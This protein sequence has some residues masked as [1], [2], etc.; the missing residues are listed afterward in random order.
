MNY[1]LISERKKWLNESNLEYFSKMEY[2]IKTKQINKNR[3][4][5]LLLELLEHIIIA[6]KEERLAEEE[7]GVDP[8]AYSK[9][10][11]ENIPSE[12]RKFSIKSKVYGFFGFMF[13]FY[14]IS[15][16]FSIINVTENNIEAYAIKKTFSELNVPYM[17]FCII[18]L[19]P[20]F[21]KI[22]DIIQI[23]VKTEHQPVLMLS[24]TGFLVILLIPLSFGLN[25]LLPLPEQLYFNPMTNLVIGI[26]G[27]II[28]IVLYKLNVK[29]KRKL[30]I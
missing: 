1:D 30:S 8:I 28:S 16:L 15:G 11:I 4:E 25:Y 17:A 29:A 26:T 6:Q 12:K 13:M 23:K 2:F 24:L 14:L 7:F 18:L 21:N 3:S 19:S 9:E 10:L 22:F 27:S 5:E 20:L